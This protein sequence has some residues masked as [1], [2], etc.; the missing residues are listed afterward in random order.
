[1][2]RECNRL[3]LGSTRAFTAQVRCQLPTYHFPHH[4]I[5]DWL[6]ARWTFG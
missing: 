6:L 4:P 2:F 1:M 3:S 5:S